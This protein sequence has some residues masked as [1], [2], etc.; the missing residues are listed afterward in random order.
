MTDANEPTESAESTGPDESAS[1]PPPPPPPAPAPPA[2]AGPPQAPPPPASAR[3]A[4]P[5]PAVKVKPSG[6]WYLLPVAL[7]VLASLV[8]LT[9]G[10]VAVVSTINR[11]ADDYISVQPGDAEAFEV[12]EAGTFVAFVEYNLE[13][14]CSSLP[15]VPNIVVLGPDGDES[16][17]RSGGVDQT[18]SSDSQTLCAIGEFSA[19]PGR[20]RMVVGPTD[21][22]IVAGAVVGPDPLPGLLR[23]FVV[24][25][26]VA[27]LGLGLAIVLAVFLLVRRRNAKRRAAVPS[28]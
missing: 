1:P 19:E 8:A 11:V 23:G 25:A 10:A 24:A 13:L 9:V 27:F 22:E 28:A 14:E 4:A 2:P 7:V 17:L 12:T 20:Y 18:W 6:W 21:T 26:V 16:V 3:S 15:D 5:A